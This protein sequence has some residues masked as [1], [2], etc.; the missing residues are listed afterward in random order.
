[1]NSDFISAEIDFSRYSLLYYFA[2]GTFDKK[3]LASKLLAVKPGSRILVYGSLDPEVEARLIS[4]SDFDVTK[5]QMHDFTSFARAYAKKQT[6][7]NLRPQVSSPLRNS[8]VKPKTYLLEN[9]FRDGG[10]GVFP[11]EKCLSFLRTH[12]KGYFKVGRYAVCV[13]AK[14]NNFYVSEEGRD[15]LQKALAQFSR[16]PPGSLSSD[17]LQ[18]S[19]PEARRV[20][21]EFGNI[22]GAGSIYRYSRGLGD[23]PHEIIDSVVYLD[24]ISIWERLGLLLNR[25]TADFVLDCLETPLREKFVLE[26]L[27]RKKDIQD[28]ASQLPD[29]LRRKNLSVVLVDAALKHKEHETAL[30]AEQDVSIPREASYYDSFEKL[31]H[32]IWRLHRAL[33]KNPTRA[34]LADYPDENDFENG[35][36]TSEYYEKSGRLDILYAVA[37]FGGIDAV[38]ERLGF[39]VGLSDE[40]SLK[41]WNNTETALWLLI[42]DAGEL[43]ARGDL[44]TTYDARDIVAGIKTYHGGFAAARER[45]GQEILRLRGRYSLADAD[46]RHRIFWFSITQMQDPQ[47]LQVF[48]TIDYEM[49]KRKTGIRTVLGRGMR[50][51]EIRE[52]FWGNFIAAGN[53]FLSPQEREFLFWFVA[54]LGCS[55]KGAGIAAKDLPVITKALCAILHKLA[56]A[57]LVKIDK[58]VRGREVALRRERFLIVEAKNS[59]RSGYFHKAIAI[60]G[61]LN[62]NPQNQK[63]ILTLFRQI[64]AAI[65]SRINAMHFWLN[66]E[67]ELLTFMRTHFYYPGGKDLE[68]IGKGMHSAIGKTRGSYDEARSNMRRLFAGFSGIDSSSHTAQFMF[69][70]KAATT[71]KPLSAKERRRAKSAINKRIEFLRK[72]KKQALINLDKSGKILKED[73]DSAISF[74]T[75]ALDIMMVNETPQFAERVC[76]KSIPLY[77]EL[78]NTALDVLR[79]FNHLSGSSPISLERHIE[80][81]DVYLKDVAGQRIIALYKRI[82][83]LYFGL[84]GNGR[85]TIEEISAML[86]I[87]QSHLRQYMVRVANYLARDETLRREAFTVLKEVE[88]KNAQNLD[89]ELA[90]ALGSTRIGEIIS[91]A[92]GMAHNS[93]NAVYATGRFNDGKFS[94]DN[95]VIGFLLRVPR[96]LPYLLPN[97]AIRNVYADE[98]GRV[99]VA[100]RNFCVKP[101]FAK[102][103]DLVCIFH[104]AKPAAVC[105][106]EGKLLAT[107]DEWG[108]AEMEIGSSYWVP[109][110]EEIL[111]LIGT[112][113]F[114]HAFTI[115]CRGA[116]LLHPASRIAV[117]EY[118]ENLQ[119]HQGDK[120]SRPRNIREFASRTRRITKQIVIEPSEIEWWSAV[121]S[122]SLYKLINKEGKF[123]QVLE[124]ESRNPSNTQELRIVYGRV[125]DNYSRARKLKTTAVMRRTPYLF[126]SQ[127]VEFIMQ[128]SEVLLA[129]ECGLGKTFTAITAALLCKAGAKTRTL[130]ICP[131]S[132][133]E[134]WRGEIIASTNLKSSD[135]YI[136]QKDSKAKD[137]QEAWF[138][139]VNYEAIRDRKGRNQL[140]KQLLGLSFDMVIVDEAHR[141]RNETL[142]TRAVLDFNADYKLLLSATPLVGRKLRK[143]F[144]LLHWLKPEIF[145]SIRAFNNL[146]AHD[147]D[148][149]RRVLSGFM[150]ARLKE[151]VA[152]DL[153][154]KTIVDVEVKFSSP[155]A[156]FYEREKQ[157][158][159]AQE[160]QGSSRQ[161]QSYRLKAAEKLMQ[162][163]I[164]P[165][166]LAASQQGYSEPLALSGKYAKVMELV[167]EVIDRGEKVVIATRYLKGV[168]QIAKI[169]SELYP[170]RVVTYT[171]E[172]SGKLREESLR[173]FRSNVS[174]QILIIS[175][176]AGGESLNLQSANNLICVDLPWTYQELLH[177]TD[178]VYRLGQKKP[179]TVYRLIARD[180]IDVHVADVLSKGQILHQ[181]FIKGDTSAALAY[182]EKAEIVAKVFGIKREEIRAYDERFR[183]LEKL[184]ASVSVQPS[185]ASQTPKQPAVK[186]QEE[187]ILA[188]PA[189]EIS[190]IHASVVGEI[191]FEHI[192]QEAVRKIHESPKFARFKILSEAEKLVVEDVLRGKSSDELRANHLACW[193]DLLRSAMLKLGISDM[194]GLEEAY[195][196]Q[197]PSLMQESKGIRSALEEWRRRQELDEEG[198]TSKTG[199]KIKGN[200]PVVCIEKLNMEEVCLALRNELR[201]MRQVEPS[202]I[203]LFARS[204]LSPPNAKQLVKS[205]D[206]GKLQA[207]ALGVFER[208]VRSEVSKLF[209]NQSKNLHDFVVAAFEAGWDYKET[210][211][212][213]NGLNNAKIEI[214][215]SSLDE[216]SGIIDSFKYKP[217]KLYEVIL[218]ENEDDNVSSPLPASLPADTYEP[219]DLDTASAKAQTA[220]LLNDLRDILC[221]LNI[222]GL[223]ILLFGSYADL[224]KEPRDVDPILMVSPGVSL[225]D[226]REI[227]VQFGDAEKSISNLLKA[228]GYGDV[229]FHDLNPAA[230]GNYFR[231][232]Q[233]REFFV[234]NKTLWLVG[235]Q[236]IQGYRWQGERIKKDIEGAIKDASSG[237]SPASSQ[238]SNNAFEKCFYILKI[239]YVPVIFTIAMIFFR[240]E[241]IAL[242]AGSFF[243]ALLVKGAIGAITGFIGEYVGQSI[244]RERNWKKIGYWAL[245]RLVLTGGLTYSI[246]YPLVNA[247]TGSAAIKVIL[248]LGPYTILF[249]YLMIMAGNWI[250]SH[251]G[252]NNKNGLRFQ[253]K[254]KYLIF[255]YPIQTA[256]WSVV[257]YVAWANF[258]Q[259]IVIFSA[260]ASGYSTILQISLLKWWI[261]ISPEKRER[262]LKWYVNPVWKLGV[263][264]CGTPSAPKAGSRK[265]SASSAVSFERKIKVLI[266]CDYNMERSPLAAA[267]LMDKLPEDLRQNVTI[268]SAG[269]S[270]R[271]PGPELKFYI[272]KDPIL[273]LH[274]PRRV[275]LDDLSSADIIFVMTKTQKQKVIRNCPAAKNKIF[276]IHKN[277]NLETVAED[278][279]SI[280]ELFLPSVRP[281]LSLRRKLTESLDENIEIIR[282]AVKRLAKPRASSS[283]AVDISL[284]KVLQFEEGSNFGDTI[285]ILNR[286]GIDVSAILK[287]SIADYNLVFS[288]VVKD[289]AAVVGE[290]LSKNPINVFV[291]GDGLCKLS[292]GNNRISLARILGWTTIP[293]NISDKAQV[294]IAS[295]PAGDSSRRRAKRRS[296][297]KADTDYGLYFLVLLDQVPEFLSGQQVGLRQAE[298]SA[299]KHCLFN[300]PAITVRTLFKWGEAQGYF[301][302]Y[303]NTAALTIEG[304]DYYYERNKPISSSPA[305]SSVA[306]I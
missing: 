214:N 8:R 13:T 136:A 294:F 98:K 1:M 167:K 41:H 63:E 35:A 127:A 215:A 163:A 291:R 54:G 185:H 84:D 4:S 210:A 292:D 12:N 199:K 2:W 88:E 235:I 17:L 234:R 94:W 115:V 159:M 222:N 142:Q 280:E 184:F 238:K 152:S 140:R 158:L 143:L 256:Y 24:A 289:N 154:G 15:I 220:A 25:E 293:A 139:V 213:L 244:K 270:K 224:M 188:K 3:E 221:R 226:G 176:K 131:K 170:G 67:W 27:K 119:R 50:I 7:N 251:A 208:N 111:Q 247:I 85:H 81:F 113:G 105:D 181:L 254:I 157:S 180:S 278:H 306:G 21:K 82:F 271:H 144:F 103:N 80:S 124:Q 53:E 175:R 36:L 39:R 305:K 250:E 187:P 233:K 99:F 64:L 258:P 243:L 257:L 95:L 52:E 260:V 204:G 302:V 216:W 203:R 43:P 5:L 288:R 192:E 11:L 92:Y 89:D 206:K 267:L 26:Y 202:T 253:D 114:A 46:N 301:T 18:I 239:I 33:K 236:Y 156:K 56:N 31:R 186:Q 28:E 225:E 90:S 68:N 141:M 40:H 108:L 282:Q 79:Y 179:V 242:T 273:K 277:L 87:R 286:L 6:E 110:R 266:L 265:K 122:D 73:M 83:R 229:E 109:G 240:Y 193:S 161:V 78:P 290:Y 227:I 268:T 297:W 55:F 9:V 272:T 130:V 145:T 232:W 37:K 194:S 107:V 201:G 172:Q 183:D 126:Q 249:T 182:D 72:Q 262:Y 146:Y 205:S 303:D 150:L 165:Y 211:N 23:I 61:D 75:Q 198:I 231:L 295:S 275:T 173:C 112:F 237:S 241:Y 45:M 287:A 174:T 58:Q 77:E 207:T 44:D 30:Q 48:L 217:Q 300:H 70:E 106:S 283:C 135:I 125:L 14:D 168:E 38:N 298:V 276:L 132:A 69:E 65:N 100:G 274:T 190:Q 178:R 101:E 123:I 91:L 102:R 261:N 93:R 177:L 284:D 19:I 29:E 281:Y 76:G 71:L 51:G 134:V 42:N 155:H 104:N 264:L 96:E 195:K 218:S 285:G 137:M 255:Y 128:N 166:L 153:P 223:E 299:K 209:K 147:L 116:N 120:I 97:C 164:S 74:A 228:K 133:I 191:L 66:L 121:I 200:D 248:D 296:P 129:D 212:L 263:C 197:I 32:E 245:A 118:M 279:P 246:F 10:W 219:A 57:S 60:V 149:L 160:A 196:T 169:L 151:E 20:A 259:W 162:A 269:L 117:R 230:R 138:V 62:K 34:Q 148:E 86:G 171:G 49:Y 59:L 16:I 304:K 22:E 252:S 189:A 47:E